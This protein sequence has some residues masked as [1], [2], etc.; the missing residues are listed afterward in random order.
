MREYRCELAAHPC[1]DH[2]DR[3]G[4]PRAAA[5][6]VRSEPR[7][8][9]P[10]RT[11]HERSARPVHRAAQHDPRPSGCVARRRPFDAFGSV[12]RAGPT[13][14][15]RTVHDALLP[16][17][18]AYLPDRA[19]RLPAPGPRLPA[20]PRFGTHS[21]PSSPARC[22]ERR[23]REVRGGRESP[24]TR[25]HRR[26]I[27]PARACRPT[28]RVGRVESPQQNRHR[29]GAVPMPG[30]TGKIQLSSSSTATAVPMPGG[31]GHKPPNRLASIRR[32]S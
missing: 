20:A 15:C 27:R 6:P 25:S 19:R 11:P 30:R 12:G 7:G 4:P 14:A 1:V 29:F 3:H 13:P 17:A 24:Q 2:A 32:S 26:P 5:G 16:R 10:G 9:C 31:T 23:S 21:R 28:C 8:R 22:I 18:R